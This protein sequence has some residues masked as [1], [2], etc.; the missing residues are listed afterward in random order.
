VITWRRHSER[1]IAAAAAVLLQAAVYLALG[2][3]HPSVRGPTS[4]PTIF[5]MILAAAS[6]KR[7]AQPVRHLSKHRNRRLVVEHSVAQPVN[8]SE[9]PKHASQSAFDWEGAIQGE[10]GEKL[11][12]PVR[13]PGMRFGFPSMPVEKALPHWDG[14]DEVRINRIQRLAHGVIDIGHCFI[15]LWPPIPQ[16]PPETVNGDLFKNM[17][18]P[19]DEPPGSLP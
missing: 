14:W 19:R 17:R 3:R 9:S 15:L 8:P 5:A 1:A 7:E 13:P 6:P 2:H 10:V 16:C 12:R 18:Q 11:T 4:P